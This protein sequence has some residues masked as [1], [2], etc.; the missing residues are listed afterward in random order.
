MCHCVI[1]LRGGGVDRVKDGGGEEK[2]NRG[3]RRAREERTG[4]DGDRKREYVAGKPE[5]RGMNGRR[6]RDAAGR[7]GGRRRR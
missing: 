2:K 1:G 4:R 7:T 6:E 5:K 3:E